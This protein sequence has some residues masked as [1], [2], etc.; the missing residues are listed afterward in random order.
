M[1]KRWSESSV[2]T[3]SKFVL[4]I[5]DAPLLDA[6]SAS[7]LYQLVRVFGVTTV[8]TARDSH[9][10]SG[11]IARLLHENLIDISRP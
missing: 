4:V 10:I 6:V 7:V 9:E 11:P 3:L 5:D 8:L 2:K 1:F